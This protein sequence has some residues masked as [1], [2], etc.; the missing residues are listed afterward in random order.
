M[1]KMTVFLHLD[2]RLDAGTY[3]ERG[4]V[5]GLLRLTPT[6]RQRGIV[7]SSDGSFSVGLAYHGQR[8]GEL[9][10]EQPSALKI[11][12]FDFIPFL[13]ACDTLLPLQVPFTNVGPIP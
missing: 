2:C 9:S 7:A 10:F 1:L 3:E 11:F 6:Q 5:N 12:L 4:I 8:L 13:C